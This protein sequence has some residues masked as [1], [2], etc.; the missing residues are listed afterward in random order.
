M[1][2][3]QS[4]AVHSVLSLPLGGMVQHAQQGGVSKERLCSLD[5]AMT[6]AQVTA[7]SEPSPA[8]SSEL[9]SDGLGQGSL[10]TDSIPAVQQVVQIGQPLVLSA[11][12]MWCNG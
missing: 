6:G 7:A 9:D 10:E 5:S 2:S 8:I 11:V 4:S 1:V 3:V 12:A